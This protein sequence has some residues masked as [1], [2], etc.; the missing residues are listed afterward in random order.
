MLLKI[1][2]FPVMDLRQWVVCLTEQN[3]PKRP[4]SQMQSPNGPPYFIKS[5][6]DLR[7]SFL[8]VGKF[9]TRQSEHIG[10]KSVALDR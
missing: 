6:F 10:P 7:L 2:L 5:T 9:F 3:L 4:S 1:N 8:S